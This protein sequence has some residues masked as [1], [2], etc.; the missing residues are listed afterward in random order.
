MN[1]KT[2]STFYAVSLRDD[3]E[4]I[5]AAQFKIFFEKNYGA[6]ADGNRGA[7]TY[8]LGD[9]ILSAAYH[10]VSGVKLT[11]D[12][13]NEAEIAAKIAMK[14]EDFS[15]LYLKEVEL[16]KAIYDDTKSQQRKDEQCD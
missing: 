7:A 16:E 2:I 8:Y 15:S 14:N 9:Y 4:V 3:R 10:D 11:D 13:H 5:V 6:D 12:E 1:C